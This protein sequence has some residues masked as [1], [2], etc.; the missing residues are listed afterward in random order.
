MKPLQRLER[1]LQRSIEQ[2]FTRLAGGKLQPV[3]MAHFLAK[4]LVA[5][6]RV[7]VDR[8]YAPNWFRAQLSTPDYRQFEPFRAQLY[9]EIR[10]YLT[11]EA[12]R[13]GFAFLGRVEVVIEEKASLK[14]GDV[15]AEAQIREDKEAPRSVEG[16]VVATE[17]LPAA[18]SNGAPPSAPGLTLVIRERGGVAQRIALSKEVDL[19]IGRDYANDLVIEDPTVSRA[20]ARVFWDQGFFVEDL[21]SRNGTFINNERVQRWHVAPGDHVRLGAVEIL[22]EQ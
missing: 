22:I 21:G 20:H 10:T 6:K 7:G 1:L 15:L 5:N 18:E 16:V 14:T 11:R 8:V 4:E 3:E 13:R 19:R 12:Q 9:E 17:N 2:P